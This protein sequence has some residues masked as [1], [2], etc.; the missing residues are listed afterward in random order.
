M[1]RRR[2]TGV[3]VVITIAVIAAGAAVAQTVFAQ[4]SA[5]PKTMSRARSATDAIPNLPAR[6]QTAAARV[7]LELNTT[8]L[9][10]TDVYLADKTDGEL[11]MV[12][13]ARGG[14]TMGCAPKDSFFGANALQY[15]ISE[16]GKPDA[17]TALTIFGVTQPSVKSVRL[18]FPSGGV[19]QTVTAG[20]GFSITAT[21]A[22]LAQGR[23]TRLIAK[24]A[25]GDT[26]QTFA[27]PQG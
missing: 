21:S 17:P 18:D 27:L 7:G 22:E 8:R 25:N 15:G 5:S 19:D 20:G 10:A 12:G 1:S 23:P 11:C 4:G 14:M 2:L 9:V 26:I 13:T 3:A 24:D 16:D 6:L